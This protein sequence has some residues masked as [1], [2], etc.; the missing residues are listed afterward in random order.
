MQAGGARMG[1]PSCRAQRQE[2]SEPIA[3]CSM[4]DQPNA[5]AVAGDPRVPPKQAPLEVSPVD[6]SP[7]STRV[8]IVVFSG[9]ALG[10]ALPE[11]EF[12]RTLDEAGVTVIF[13][14]DVSSSWYTAGVPGLGAD[15]AD[16]PRGLDEVLRSHGVNRALALGN[17]S[18][19]FAAL[20]VGSRSEIVQDA[21]VFAPQTTISRT[22]RRRWHDRR[23][24]GKINAIHEQI[25]PDNPEL[26]V[27]NA[28]SAARLSG[29]VYF[30]AGSRLDAM[31]AL[32]LLRTPSID[33]APVMDRSHHPVRRLRSKGQLRGLIRQRVRQLSNAT[34]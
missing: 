13:I 8:G 19:G 9:L 34:V 14:R 12:R 31:H 4:R 16:L 7:R 2:A 10:F 15:L 17:S 32:R 20:S 27:L 6:V 23:W 3:C 30:G 33:L 18:G 21:L 28:L 26:D 22:W 25:G 29:R 24:A 1:L 5:R 11:F